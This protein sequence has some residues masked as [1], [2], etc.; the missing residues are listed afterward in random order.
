MSDNTSESFENVNT[1][2]TEDITSVLQ[3]DPFAKGE[4]L[5]EVVEETPAVTEKPVEVPAAVV[6]ENVP[7][8]AAKNES[9]TEEQL[10]LWKELADARQAALDKVST[11]K[12]KG[13]AGEEAPADALPAYDFEIPDQLVEALT[14]SDVKVFKQGV[15]ALAK[16]LAIAIHGQMQK[17]FE[18]VYNQR[19]D[20]LPAQ[21]MQ[22]IQAASQKQAVFQDFYGKNPELNKPALYPIV[23]KVA[24]E[25][26]KRLKKTAWDDE[27]RDV[28]AK[29]VKALLGAVSGNSAPAATPA[30]AQMLSSQGARVGASSGSKLEQEIASIMFDN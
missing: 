24:E 20:S 1:A 3:Y 25:A 11:D 7:T 27:L 5:P 10:R 26:A 12:G 28:V 19:F 6:E 14:T 29:D 8:N 4:K 30:P 23:T 13:A 21:V 22:T 18:S 16:G 17:Q 15:T 9:D 2:P